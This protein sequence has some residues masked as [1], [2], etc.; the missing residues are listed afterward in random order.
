[1][2]AGFNSQVYYAD[3]LLTVSRISRSVTW[4]VI[5]KARFALRDGFEFRLGDESSSFW[6]VNWYG[7]GKL[8]EKVLYVDIHDLNLRVKD[9]FVNGA[10]NFNHLYTTLPL[11][12]RDSLKMIPICLNSRVI[13]GYT[14]K[15]NLNGIHSAHDG[16]YWLNKFAFAAGAVETVSW[17]RIWQLPTP[18]KIKFFL[19]IAL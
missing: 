8:A 2:G 6:F 1:M 14:L 9:A 7:I 10:W 18:E 13:V 5:M 15:G 16:Y 11:A 4:N 12:V 19:W 17:T 3:M